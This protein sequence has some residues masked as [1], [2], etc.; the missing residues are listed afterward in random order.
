MAIACVEYFV[1]PGN[2][3]PHP[4]LRIPR[5]PQY[6]ALDLVD[7]QQA[8]A[9]ALISQEEPVP[10]PAEGAPRVPLRFAGTIN[11]VGGTILAFLQKYPPPWMNKESNLAISPHAIELELSL[12]ILGVSGAAAG[13]VAS[14]H[15][16][17]VCRF[18]YVADFASHVL[19]VFNAHNTLLVTPSQASVT[20]LHQAGRAVHPSGPPSLFN[21][22]LS[23]STTTWLRT[24]LD[25]PEP[26]YVNETA[27]ALHG[28]VH[29]TVLADKSVA[30]ADINR[31]IANQT[32][33][34][35][36]VALDVLPENPQMLL[37]SAVHF[38]DLWFRPF[39]GAR[40]KKGLF[41]TSLG[42]Y[43]N[44]RMMRTMGLFRFWEGPDVQA[45]ELPYASSWAMV[46]LY[47]KAEE[48]LVK[49][50]QEAK[51]IADYLVN[52][53]NWDMLLHTHLRWKRGRVSVPRVSVDSLVDLSLA[54]N[55]N[56][57]QRLYAPGGS[58]FTQV[59]RSNPLLSAVYHR[60][61]LD[62]A[63]W[64]TDAGPPVARAPPSP[65]G[66]AG[67]ALPPA[68]P[69]DFEMVLDHPFVFA[70]RECLSDTMLFLGIVRSV[71]PWE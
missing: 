61:R 23:W 32:G 50:H 46:V 68:R 22:S 48:G 38:R 3:T 59:A 21:V 33:Y 12:A 35:V 28:T 29:T 2:I 57:W 13:Q 27:A 37:M 66:P 11:R 64:G 69:M 43:F 47:P 30:L 10:S 45:I 16:T 55:R 54:L 58:N 70:V 7:P 60:V 4:V 56:F 14:V 8:S 15:N 36:P 25:S 1:L 51:V 17:T 20:L 62:I 67:S 71:D 34:T 52:A 18:S 40:V 5:T 24:D 6:T 49:P 44:C 39:E 9:D 63:E 65:G 53:T 19:K 42:G 41:R 26:L 31:V